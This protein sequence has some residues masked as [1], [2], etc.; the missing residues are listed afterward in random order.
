[1]N[2]RRCFPLA[3][4]FVLAGVLAAAAPCPALAHGGAPLNSL[5]AGDVSV[6]QWTLGGR[7]GIDEG[8]YQ[9]LEGATASARDKDHPV[10]IVILVDRNDAEDVPWLFARPNDY[11]AFLGEYLHEAHGFSG[12]LLAVTPNGIGVYPPDLPTAE[13]EAARSVEVEGTR[14]IDSL[15]SSALVA[16]QRLGVAQTASRKGGVPPS[17]KGTDWAVVAGVGAATL[18]LT[19]LAGTFAVLS[20]RRRPRP[21]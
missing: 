18:V 12:V 9:R 17:T 8:L 3:A 1:M 16:L 4:A 6:P 11:A 2:Q 5:I 10:K 14:D 19:G 21:L 15:A 7:Y 20:R 13:V